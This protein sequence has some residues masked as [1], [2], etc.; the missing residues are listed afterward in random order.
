M[1]LQYS[2]VAYRAQSTLKMRGNEK[3]EGKPAALPD[4]DKNP[5]VL[6]LA[7]TEAALALDKEKV[8][9][10][11]DTDTQDSYKLFKDKFETSG[12]PKIN[13]LIQLEKDGRINRQTVQEKLKTY[14]DQFR[15]LASRRMRHHENQ[16]DEFRGLAEFLDSN[17]GYFDT[18]SSNQ[19]IQNNFIGAAQKT[20][21]HTSQRKR[22][23]SFVEQL[24]GHWKTFMTKLTAPA[25]ESKEEPLKKEA[26]PQPETRQHLTLDDI[27]QELTAKPW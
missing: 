25:E 22:W 13:K 27:E 18:A 1:Q 6:S 21:F 11:E 16:A 9:L 24:D 26:P 23:E 3:T 10:L 2:P 20:R 5:S 19:R 14:F 4:A 12:I 8:T 15:Q 7:P 17:D